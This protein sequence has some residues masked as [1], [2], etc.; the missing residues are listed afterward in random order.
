MVPDIPSPSKPGDQTENGRLYKACYTLLEPGKN[1]NFVSSTAVSNLVLMAFALDS[2]QA[3]QIASKIIM[4]K[5]EEENLLDESTFLLS[6]GGTPLQIRV[7]TPNKKSDR[8]T[9]KQIS[10][11]VIKE[12]QVLLELSVNKTKALVSSLRRGI[13]STSSIQKN[14]GH[15]EWVR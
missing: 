4:K 11:Q 3:E 9:V 13:G 6:T 15:L 7:G 5:M 8:R 2:L 12:L 1:H 14:L 10:L